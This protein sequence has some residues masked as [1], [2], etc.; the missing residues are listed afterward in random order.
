MSGSSVARSFSLAVLA[1]CSLTFSQQ[2]KVGWSLGYYPGWAQEKNP[3]ASINWASVTHIVHFTLFPNNDGTLDTAYCHINDGFSKAL[4]AEAH[5][6]GVKALIALGGAEVGTRFRNAASNANRG[7]LISNMIAFIKT[8][9][10][11]GIDIDWEESFDNTLILALFKDMRDSLDKMT[12]PPLLTTPVA[13]YYVNNC[14]FVHPYVS[15]LNTMD[16]Y[17]DVKGYP[18]QLKAFTDKGV[19]KAKLGL[20]LGIGTGANMAVHD[21]VM[22]KAIADFAIDNGYGGIMEWTISLAPLNTQVLKALVPY[23]PSH[24]TSIRGYGSLANVH[25]SLLQVRPLNAGHEIRYTVPYGPGTT[26]FLDLS[27]YTLQG[28]R[29]RNLVHGPSTGGTYVL[30]LDQTSGPARLAHSGA[31]VLR[32]NA[33]S[34]SESARISITP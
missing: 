28:A 25:G 15:Q 13:A 2:K 20:G 17:V 29:V 18:A 8:Y 12:P 16:Y 22:A 14:Y 27:L 4:V 21:T 23:I 34:T 19:P 11:D 26:A 31:Y 5:K 30:S 9:G 3:P 7:K 1:M 33:G 6:H 10:H 24:S 32:L